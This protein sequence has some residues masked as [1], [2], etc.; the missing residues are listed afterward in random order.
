VKQQ[1]LNWNPINFAYALQ[2]LSL[3]INNV[4]GFLKI[5]HGVP[6]KEVPFSF[7]ENDETYDE[8]WKRQFG[9]SS[10]GMNS[11]ISPEGISPVTKEEILAVY[12]QE[13]DGNN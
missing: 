7:C 6:I 8:P 12:D 10:F 13:Q 1:S 4:T 3:S 9:I 11:Q 5:L 2:L